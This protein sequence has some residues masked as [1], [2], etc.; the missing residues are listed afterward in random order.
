MYHSTIE[1][2]AAAK[3]KHNQT[4]RE[5]AKARLNKV[6]RDKRGRKHEERALNSKASAILNARIKDWEDMTKQVS[7]KAPIGAY[8]KPGSLNRF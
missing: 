1:S 4:L 6:A 8:T 7:F 3:A 5:N 2:H